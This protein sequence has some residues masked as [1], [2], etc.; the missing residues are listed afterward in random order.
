MYQFDNLVILLGLLYHCNSQV[1]PILGCLQ[2]ASNTSCKTCNSK[3]NWQLDAGT[4]KC[5]KDHTNPVG[6]QS[7]VKTKGGSKGSKKSGSGSGSSSSSGSGSGS[8][9]GS[10]NVNF[11]NLVGSGKS[12]SGKGSKDKC[13]FSW[14]GSSKTKKLSKCGLCPICSDGFKLSFI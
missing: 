2:Y 11:A 7:C 9:S 1:N 12:G 14:S 8:G 4:C 10:H 5:K 13:R 6:C 3:L